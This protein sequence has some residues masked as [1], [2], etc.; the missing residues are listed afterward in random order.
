M[1]R[2]RVWLARILGLA[3]GQ[4]RDCDLQ[5]EI[6]SH[7]QMHIDELVR[8]GS[9]LGEARRIAHLKFGAVEAAKEQYRDRRG[10]PLVE[11]TLRDLRH[12]LRVWARSPGFTAIALASLALGIGANTAIFS[13]VNSLVLRPLPVRDPDQLVQIQRTATQR[14]LSNPIWEALRAKSDLFARAAAWS[15]TTFNMADGGEAQTVSGLW[16]SGEF[17]ETFG[18]R[19]RLGRLL[20][21]TDD[22]RGGGADGPV[23]VLS[24]GF[25]QRQFGGAQDVVGRSLRLAGVP[26]TVVGVAPPEFFGGEVG[27]TFD[28]AV[29]LGSEPLT[30]PRS[31][32]DERAGWWLTV[33]ARLKAGQTIDGAS[34]AVHE[35]Q[36]SVRAATMP[37][38]YRP[39]EQ[40]RYLLAPMAVTGMS[41]GVSGLRI[42]YEQPLTIVMVVVGVVL[43][44]AC[45]NLANLLLARADGRRHEMSV[46][47]ALGAS[48]TRLIRQ[49]CL[50]SL[51]LSAAGAALGLVFAAWSSEL[52]V[53]QL[54]TGTKL[55]T[56]TPAVRLPLVL[57]WRVLAFASA[58]AIVSG[59][60]FG[61]APA[62]RATRA[63]ANDALKAHGR[64]AADGRRTIGS[65]L[66]VA[67]VALSLV[68]VIGAGLFVRTFTA[69]SDVP[70]GFDPRPLLIVDLNAAKS[71]TPPEARLALFE[72][73]RE[74]VTSLPGVSAAE[75][76]AMTPLAGQWDQIIENPEGLSLSEDDRDVYLNAVGPDWFRTYGTALV[77]GRLLTAQDAG[78]VANLP[79]VVNETFAHK[80]YRDRQVL[81]AVVRVANDPKASPM[82]IVGIVQDAVYDSMRDRVP[83][84]IYQPLVPAPRVSLS[85][86]VR[87]STDAPSALAHAIAAAAVSVDPTLSVTARPLSDRV[88]AQTIRERLLAILSA[89]FGGLALV[90]AGLGLYGVVSYAVSRRRT[91]I[92]IRMAL[93]A[94]GRGVI[95]LVVRR[96]AVVVLIGI[97]AGGALGLWASR[98]VQAQLFGLAPDDAA[99][100]AGA[101]VVLVIVAAVASWWP[102]YRASHVDPAKALR[103]S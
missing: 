85:L 84:T 69:L 44:I 8:A 10:L 80:Y 30:R 26:F 43:L 25:W 18:V 41:T 27:R 88:N 76:S 38:D 100:F 73:V 5:A 4:R 13:I 66:V 60:I 91:E 22:R 32:L 90:L 74:R 53:N 50:E 20:T 35:I 67:Q 49:M 46:R 52:L 28:V 57:D 82:S 23:A 94:S 64:S 2:W 55:S 70:F 14:T 31:L 12:G 99:T 97:A 54:S 98:L 89:F 6:N 77:A 19:P 79:I 37:T 102:A 56:G 87:S 71:A 16:V 95:Q 92:G 63:E 40:A 62:W 86:T 45:V 24:Y 78:Q 39:A 72:R 61:L 33:C 9:P 103:E 34:R 1:R 48:R 81:G 59:L 7:L 68:L 65:A 101:T 36:P 21:E 96:V 17:F 83:P 3:G 93:G 42:A 75:L 51:L 15:A 29:P 58:A 47:L 11:T